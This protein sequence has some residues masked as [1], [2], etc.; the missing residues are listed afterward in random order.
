MRFG[1]P[2]PLVI[3]APNSTRPAQIWPCAC[4]PDPNCARNRRVKDARRSVTGPLSDSDF[5]AVK[6]RF[7]EN[8][9]AGYNRSANPGYSFRVD[10]SRRFRLLTGEGREKSITV[11]CNKPRFYPGFTLGETREYNLLN[12]ITPR[13]SLSLSRPAAYLLSYGSTAAVRRVAAREQV[14]HRAREERDERARE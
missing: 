9:M 13:Y 11:V 12:L 5:G 4:V 3:W 1:A 14:E 8:E 7:L 6:A 2:K 10:S